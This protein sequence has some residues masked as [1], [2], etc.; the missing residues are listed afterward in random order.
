MPV[1]K[2]SRSKA[3][4]RHAA[5]RLA[6]MATFGG[7]VLSTLPILYLSVFPA[8]T[9]AFMLHRKQAAA[10]A[11]RPDFRL[12]YRW[13][14]LDAMAYSAPLAVMAAED[15]RFPT[16]R[17][18]DTE[19]MRKAVRDRLDGKPLRGASTLTQQVAKNLFL[20]PGKNPVRKA[21]EAYFTVLIELL[22]PKRRILEVYLNIAELGDGVYGVEAASR[23][24]FD[25]PARALSATEAALLASALPAPRR[26]RVERPSDHMRRK[27]RW[28][29]EQM[30][31]LSQRGWLAKVGISTP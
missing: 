4:R 7:L 14:P 30:S 20:W 22:W 23:R 28:I 13:V 16:H 26:F 12:R 6:L 25:H 27:Q 17:G 5:L 3:R 9:S 1:A 29:R 21:L 8:P 18:F 10:A 24:F 19:A 2:R 31:V 15:Q 11:G